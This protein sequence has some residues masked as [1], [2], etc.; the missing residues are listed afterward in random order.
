VLDKSQIIIIL[1]VYTENLRFVEDLEMAAFGFK[2]LRSLH[3]LF[4]IP[5]I[6]YFVFNIFVFRAWPIWDSAFS[7]IIERYIGHA[8]AD[9]NS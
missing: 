5:L 4:P 1:F 2:S 6:N 8:A 9:G 3:F 7:K